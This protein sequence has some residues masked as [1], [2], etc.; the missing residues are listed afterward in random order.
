MQALFFKLESPVLIDLEIDWPGPASPEVWP[1]RSRDLYAGEPMVVTAR[2]T[3]EDGIIALSG[4]VLGGHWLRQHELESGREHS[5]IAAL[6]ARGKIESLMDQRIAGGDPDEIR[7][8]V[9][10]TALRHRLVSRYTSLVAI[11]RTPARPAGVGLAQRTVPG[12]AP[13]GTHGEILSGFPQTATPAALHFLVSAICLFC[14]V[15]LAGSSRG[16]TNTSDPAASGEK[17]RRNSVVRSCLR[18]L[19]QA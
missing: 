8:Q 17:R 18:H 6:W 12:V 11:D 16:R 15:L 4:K 3:G 13:Q 5:G 10:E 14:A 19:S 7:A 2:L 9:V 1:A